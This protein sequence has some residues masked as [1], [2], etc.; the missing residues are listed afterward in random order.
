MTHLF[1]LKKDGIT[2]GYVKLWYWGGLLYSEDL[3][4]DLMTNKPELPREIEGEGLTF[5]PFVCKDK[6]D[7]DVFDDDPIWFYWMGKKI[8]AKVIKKDF[9]N[10]LV[11]CEGEARGLPRTLCKSD[12]QHIELIEEVTN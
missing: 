3:R 5:H 10:H 4:F 11:S 6:N 2:V 12:V 1:K 8:K 7:K 9:F